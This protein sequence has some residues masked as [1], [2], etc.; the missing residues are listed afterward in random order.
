[1][2]AKRTSAKDE[3]HIREAALVL[4]A[5]GI[6]APAAASFTEVMQLR[7]HD[8]IGRIDAKTEATA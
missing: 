1:M 4:R 5:G 6:V 2:P 3:S 8:D 7:F